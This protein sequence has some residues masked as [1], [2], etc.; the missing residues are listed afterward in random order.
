[1]TK[2]S[3]GSHPGQVPAVPQVGAEPESAPAPVVAGPV[4]YV[5]AVPLTV[6]GVLAFPAGAVVP[7]SH[8]RL[9]V[10]LARG[11]VTGA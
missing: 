8:P 9:P 10:W 6:G 2:S 1:M 11:D 5:A 7:P 4:R 3:Q